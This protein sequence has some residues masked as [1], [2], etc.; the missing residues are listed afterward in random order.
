MP[1]AKMN[2]TLFSRLVFG[3][4]GED[5]PFI[6]LPTFYTSHTTASDP[7]APRSLTQ[8]GTSGA[9]S[10]GF[11]CSPVLRSV[12]GASRLLGPHSGA[13]HSQAAQGWRQ[14]FSGDKAPPVK[15]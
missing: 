7:Q 1:G 2:L 12:P 5:A 6:Q 15:S 8:Y 13:P 14:R 9:E 4:G 10:L 11:S 3:K